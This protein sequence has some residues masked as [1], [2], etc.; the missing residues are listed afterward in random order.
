M[1]QYNS[2]YKVN[3][4]VKKITRNNN[5][6]LNGSIVKTNTEINTLP[7]CLVN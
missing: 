3:S 2:T 1:S 5:I 7:C 6:N 4:L